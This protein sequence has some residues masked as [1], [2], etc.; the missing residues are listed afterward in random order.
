MRAIV[1]GTGWAG[2]GHTLG[3]R[4]AGVDVVALC[5]R[6]P[7][8]AK[9]AAERLGIDDLR[10]DYRQAIEDL[11]PDIVAIG[12][13]V[14]PHREMAEAAAAAGCH[15]VCDK[16]LAANAADA[17]AML[18]AVTATGVRHGYPTVGALYPWVTLARSLVADGEIGQLRHIDLLGRGEPEPA[19]P[20]S[21]MSRLA[22]GGG[23]LN[24]V[25]SHM[26]QMI[27]R[28]AGAELVAVAGVATRWVD[29]RAIGDAHHIRDVMEERVD[30]SRTD[31]EWRDVDVDD[32]IDVVMRLRQAAGGEIT[33][34]A[35]WERGRPPAPPTALIQGSEATFEVTGIDAQE[36]DV[37]RP[38]GTVEPRT[39][40]VELFVDDG[41]GERTQKA[42]NRFFAR[43]VRDVSG[44]PD[45]DY[46][47]FHDGYVC[48][49]AIDAIRSGSG[50]VTIRDSPAPA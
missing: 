5:G 21:W 45:G 29:R 27:R 35:R 28:V 11:R 6:T 19:T 17:K 14:A 31:L 32:S 38:D 9:A 46:P 16:P 34:T 8:H 18:D 7:E 47:T 24:T 22:D 23:A 44:R 15:V 1:I 12:T 50:M 33:A 37:H 3:L 43:F 40:P 26:L 41:E 49:Q 2:E 13:T 42:W 39:I 48:C 20:Y 30:L 4:H 25:F 36:I 10:F